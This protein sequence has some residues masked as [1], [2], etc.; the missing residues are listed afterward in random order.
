MKVFAFIEAE[1]ANFSIQF[2]CE[3]LGVSTS[4]FYAWRTRPPSPRAVADA[5]LLETIT[6][7]HEQSRGTYGAPRV[8]AELRLD[9]D[10]A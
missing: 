9:H 8:H 2:M 4:G 3:R 7:V 6:T 10:I 5:E 1:K